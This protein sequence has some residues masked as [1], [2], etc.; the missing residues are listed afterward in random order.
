MK[1]AEGA[2]VPSKGRDEDTEDWGVAAGGPPRGESRAGPQPPR[3]PEQ[4]AGASQLPLPLRSGPSYLLLPLKCLSHAR[5]ID[6]HVNI[7]GVP[8]FCTH[9]NQ[10][11]LSL[12]FPLWLVYITSSS[13]LFAWQGQAS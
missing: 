12:Y 1:W 5:G 8:E 9:F 13:L 7:S 11:F 2:K 4:G 3:A 10:S 6:E